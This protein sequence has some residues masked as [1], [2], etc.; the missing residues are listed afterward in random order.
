MPAV[1]N[2][3]NLIRTE[4]EAGVLTRFGSGLVRGIRKEPIV[5]AAFEGIAEATGVPEETLDRLGSF[6][7]GSG[8]GRAGEIIGEFA[9]S[10]IGGLGAFTLGRMALTKAVQAIAP[11]LVARGAE[12][13]LGK[14]GAGILAGAQGLPR[15]QPIL[16]RGAQ[17][18]GGSLGLGSFSGAEVKAA[19]GTN[20]EA[21]QAAGVTAA[22]VMGFEGAL[23]GGGRL[24][25]PRARSTPELLESAQALSAETGQRSLQKSL[26]RQDIERDPITGRIVAT[27]SGIRVKLRNAERR[28][29]EVLKKEQYEKEVAGQ[30]E[31][32]P[33]EALQAKGKLAGGGTVGEQGEF[34]FPTREAAVREPLFRTV[35]RLERQKDIL[36]RKIAKLKGQVGGIEQ[37]KDISGLVPMDVTRAM[38][39]DIGV[40]LLSPL[41]L[42]FRK[43]LEAP[44]ATARKLGLPSIRAIQMV[45]DAEIDALAQTGVAQVL[46][47]KF[48]KD[49]AKALRVKNP[50]STAKADIMLDPVVHTFQSGGIDAVAQQFGDDV[51]RLIQGADDGFRSVYAPIEKQ[52]GAPFLARADMEKLGI[53]GGYWPG[54]IQDITEEQMVARLVQGKIAEAAKRGV[55]MSREEAMVGVQTAMDKTVRNG[56][57]RFGSFDFLRLGKGTL[58]ERIERGEPFEGPAT[59]M[60]RY[61]TEAARRTAHGARF[62]DDTRAFR[63]AVV[64]ASVKEGADIGSVN[65][66]MDGFF[67]RPYHTF[68]RRRLA[69]TVTSTQ[70]GTKMF[71]SSIPN[72]FQ[73]GV[74][75]PMMFGTR[76]TIRGLYQSMRGLTPKQVETAVAAQESIHDSWRRVSL[77]AGKDNLMDRIA[78]ATLKLNLF[79]TFEQWNRVNSGGTAVVTLY[80]DLGKA[81]A[82][83]LRGVAADAARRRWGVMRLDFDKVVAESKRS[84]TRGLEEII[85]GIH[86]EGAMMRAT[87]RGAREVQFIPIRTR[88][89]LVVQNPVGRVMF[90]FKTFALNQGKLIRDQVM[91]EAARGNIKPLVHFLAVYPI[92][93]ELVAGSVAAGKGKDRP[94]GIQRMLQ[95]GAAVGGFGLVSSVASAARWGEVE[96]AFMGPAISDGFEFFENMIQIDV[97]GF[98]RQ[99]MQQP[100]ASG[101]RTVMA[102]IGVTAQQLGELFGD[103]DETPLA[104][105]PLRLGAVQ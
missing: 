34:A 6:A 86:G 12:T 62:G 60:F 19:G 46:V 31:A 1:I 103:E 99:L 52:G 56:I 32:F 71:W 17:A 104:F 63:D 77:G 51:A 97:E 26:F 98:H 2:R 91:G 81:V 37:V 54:V 5:G 94:D 3:S 48:I 79:S 88:S 59:A 41:R 7:A 74:N 82:G 75:T 101:L 50:G 90:Q 29:R 40:G 55:T 49:M 33:P 18:V 30:M 89:P 100:I 92:A 68:A 25:S 45:E 80:S 21:L 43:V 20:E 72:F 70:I 35:E 84:P 87:F 95:D 102:A 9:P 11:R 14:Q 73:F 105:E 22:I 69:Q 96:S 58:R 13:F 53:P 27:E 78:Q 8:V 66:L 23:I 36:R 42:F 24:L 15:A 57:R 47:T 93:G 39:V 83:R 28:Y 85:D 61:L 65:T 38:P 16:E 10:L 44:E 4:G 64:A 67:G 76:N